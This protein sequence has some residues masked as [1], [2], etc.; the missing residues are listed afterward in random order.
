MIGQIQTES[1]GAPFISRYTHGFPGLLNELNLSL[2]ISTYQAGKII[3]ISAGIQ[4]GLKQKAVSIPK[5]MGI[6]VNNN[7]IAVAGRSHIYTLNYREEQAY[8]TGE[9][10]LHD[11]EY[12][13]QGL[14]AVNTRYSCIGLTDKQSPFK[15][16]WMPFFI[17]RPEPADQCHLNGMCLREGQLQYVTALGR[18]NLP[19][20]WRE[21]KLRGGILMDARKN[22]ILLEG[23]PMPH[24]PRLIRGEL[25]GLHSATGELVRYDLERGGYEVVYRFKGFVRGLVHAGDYIFVG[26]SRL[27]QASDKIGDLPIAEKELV[28]GV[29]AVRLSAA[30]PAGRIVY[31]TEIE[32]IYDVKLI[33]STLNG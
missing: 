9:L 29:E 30:Q 17:E 28:C 27:R 6:A 31:L 16:T 14:L 10:D 1:P 20:G 11:M 2:V 4:G 33:Q 25:Y 8:H 21:N 32:E 24:S 12:T 5:P 3:R 13:H 19:E 26:L 23:L 7:Q 18:S 22:E 15:P